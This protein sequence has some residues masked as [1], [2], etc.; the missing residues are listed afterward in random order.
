MKKI[1]FLLAFILSNVVAAQTFEVQSIYNSGPDDKRI[2][3][4]ILSDGY[5]ASE[6]GAFITDANSF[7]NALFA[8]SPYL[9]YKNYF[10]VYAIKVPSNQSGA[11]HPGTATDVTEPVI[12]V[13]VVD[14]YF[15]STFDYA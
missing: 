12:P 11:S 6:L 15:G 13:A 9:E 10:N 5:Q 7:T 2:N 4:V 3:L 1:T 14:N 8:E